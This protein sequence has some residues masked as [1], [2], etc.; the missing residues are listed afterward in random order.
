MAPA[1]FQPLSGRIGT[2]TWAVSLEPIQRQLWRIPNDFLEESS[3]ICQSLLTDWQK[4]DAIKRFTKPQL[5]Y[6]LRTLLP[7][8][9]WA[10]DVDCSLRSSLKKGLRLPGCTTSNFLYCHQDNGGLGVPSIE[11][12]MD[13]AIVSQ[14]FK[15][16]SNKKDPRVSTVAHHQLTEVMSKR[17]QAT[18]P[19][20]DSLST[21]LNTPAPN[22]EGSRGDMRSLWSL[23]RKSL[24]NTHSKILLGDGGTGT[25]ISIRE[26][27]G[28]WDQRKSI[29]KALRDVCQDNHLSKLLEAKD[30]GRSFFSTSRHSAS[31][32]WIQ[33]G[34]CH[35]L[36]VPFRP[37]GPPQPP[38]SKDSPETHQSSVHHHYLQ[39]LSQHA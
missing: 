3:A 36:P 38:P 21:F 19:S 35:F 9:S 31:N 27:T 2:N 29:S 28:G 20:S 1:P 10:K 32:Y 8:R 25:K 14:A 17:P 23:V 24:Q 16:L 4:I 13:I 5:D 12:E 30:Q 37:Q 18:D 6:K 26:C 34:H 39:D 15:F 22:G 7:S 33:S 11:D